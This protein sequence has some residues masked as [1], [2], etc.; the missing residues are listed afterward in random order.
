MWYTIPLYILYPTFQVLFR[1]PRAG[2][3]FITVYSP[4]HFANNCWIKVH[5]LNRMTKHLTPAFS[6]ECPRNIY[7]RYAFFIRLFKNRFKRTENISPPVHHFQFIFLYIWYVFFS[8]IYVSWKMYLFCL[9]WFGFWIGGAYDYVFN[10]K[11]CET[12]SHKWNTIWMNGICN[13]TKTHNYSFIYLFI[14]LYIQ[15][16][17]F[18]NSVVKVS[19]KI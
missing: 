14:Y 2:R 5:A 9:N 8:R 3:E 1:D 18:F 17:A 10:I 6:S 16:A 11:R 12:S 7:Y 13:H 19:R 4:K 15:N